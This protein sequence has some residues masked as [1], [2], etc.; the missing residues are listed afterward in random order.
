MFKTQEAK[1]KE[2]NRKQ[3]KWHVSSNMY[4]NKY[5][6]SVYINQKTKIDI[7]D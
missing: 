1:G 4:Y 5:K 2:K 3:T 6:W 7:V